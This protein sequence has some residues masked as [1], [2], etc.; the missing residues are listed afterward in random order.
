MIWVKYAA[1]IDI[2]REFARRRAHIEDDDPG[3]LEPA[4]GFASDE[5]CRW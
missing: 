1:T 3:I 4:A 5:R 2:Q